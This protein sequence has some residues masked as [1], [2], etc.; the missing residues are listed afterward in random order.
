MSVDPF[1]LFRESQFLAK[2]S[3]GSVSRAVADASDGVY[4]TADGQPGV[5]FGPMP[6]PYV[7]L[8]NVGDRILIMQG[9]YGNP[10]VASWDPFG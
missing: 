2:A 5:E 9:P 7:A 10:W 6:W 3:E 1:S 8:P 4:A